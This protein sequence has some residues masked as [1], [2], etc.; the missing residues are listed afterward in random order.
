MFNPNFDEPL[1]AE[2]LAAEPSATREE[3]IAFINYMDQITGVDALASLLAY[4][5][6]IDELSDFDDLGD[7]D[8]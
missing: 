2:L 4:P 6:D 5:G 7:L 3:A 1:V 8:W